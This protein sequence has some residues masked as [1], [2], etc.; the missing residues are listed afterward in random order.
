M[1]RLSK[2]LTIKIMILLISISAISSANNV[3]INDDKELIENPEV[4]RLDN[5]IEVITYIEGIAFDVDKTGFIFNKPIEITA[6]KMS[7][8]LIG[9]K[10]P[11]DFL[12]DILHLQMFFYISG[13]SYVKASRFFGRVNDDNNPPSVRGFAIGTIEWG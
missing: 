1:I 5:Q 6:Y 11:S 3:N 10:L 4:E 7:I 13:I 8:S 9:I 2:I 12:H